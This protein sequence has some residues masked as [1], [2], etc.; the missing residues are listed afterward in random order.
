MP[1][2]RRNKLLSDCDVGAS[3]YTVVG[4]ASL[5]NGCTGRAQPELEPSLAVCFPT[6]IVEFAVHEALE[7]ASYSPGSYS[8]WLTPMQTVR[9]TCLAGAV[10][11]NFLH[12]HRGAW[13]HCLSS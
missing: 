5:S 12:L 13:L 6:T 10:M 7:I 8:L 9:S 1:A 2:A 4:F 3:H 11:T